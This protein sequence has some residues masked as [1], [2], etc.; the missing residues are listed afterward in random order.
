MISVAEQYVTFV[1]GEEMYAVPVGQVR[2]IVRVSKITRVPL[3]PNHV[4]GVMNL[5][6]EVL[7]IINLRKLLNLPPQDVSSSKIMVLVHE[8]HALGVIVDRTAQV[9]R[10]SGEEEQ[11]SSAQS[12]F[13]SKVIRTTNG[14]CLLFNTE[15]IFESQSR[16]GEVRATSFGRETSGEKVSTQK[17]N[18]VQ[19]V[20]FELSGG[21]YA[22]KIDGVQEIIRYTEPTAVP[23]AEH[24]LR[25]LVE[26]RN[27]ILPII[28]LRRLL[29]LPSEH[30]DEFTKV[31][32]LKLGKSLVGV[33]VDRIREVLRIEESKLLPP[34]TAA[35]QSQAKELLG[36]V[37]FDEHMIMVL[38]YA[39]LISGKI[40]SLS[41]SEQEQEIKGEG[42]SSG[43]EKQYVIFKVGGEE[44]GVQ[45]EEIR[46]VNRL[47]TL[48]KIPKAPDYLV[49]LMNLRG[50][51]LPVIDL[52]KRF[53]IA[54]AGKD[55]EMVRVIVTET[56]GRKT[57]FVVDS[58]VGV[59]KI[60]TAS[61][62][63]LPETI[64]LGEAARFVSKIARI[65]DR[66]ILLLQMERI[67]TE[68]EKENVQRI[69]DRKD[70]TEDKQEKKLKRMK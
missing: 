10:V 32:V 45:I 8:G 14:L 18:Y 31:I 34:P 13:V 21:V 42:V 39:A 62:A 50:E 65:D 25:G 30:V 55:D 17:S 47:T 35:Q 19:L 4:E 9:I 23:S 44:Y 67:L 33:V 38:D 24:C 27:R 52:R 57:A 48:T 70:S 16:G 69:V 20:T 59:Q 29:E 51:V 15:K 64:A 26:L 5:R 2:E 36:V 28:D 58:V 12:Q 68:R 66:V 37:H 7:P 61:I 11:E 43:E 40:Y 6:G 22:F 49:G 56:A 54:A 53:G 63:D 3:T 60:S 1:L 46:E 41:E